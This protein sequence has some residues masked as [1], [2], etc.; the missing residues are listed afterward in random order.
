MRCFFVVNSLNI[1]KDSSVKC[2]PPTQ[3][4]PALAAALDPLVTLTNLPRGPRSKRN[5]IARRGATIALLTSDGSPGHPPAHHGRGRG[6]STDRSHRGSRSEDEDPRGRRPSQLR[7]SQAL[8]ER[9]LHPRYEPSRTI[10]PDGPVRVTRPHATR[11]RLELFKIGAA[12]VRHTGPVK[13]HPSGLWPRREL[14]ETAHRRLVPR[15]SE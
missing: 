7:G 4:N 9:A 8:A 11:V 6:E 2:L 5:G 13:V 3:T 14:F 12:V 10:I 1:S 15:P